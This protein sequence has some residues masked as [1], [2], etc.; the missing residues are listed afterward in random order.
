MAIK[1]CVRRATSR[2]FSRGIVLAFSFM[3]D[4]PVGA[5]KTSPQ[6]VTQMIHKHEFLG[7]MTKENIKNHIVSNY[8]R[9]FEYKDPVFTFESDFD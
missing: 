5:F 1:I 4:F 9:L 3:Y 8:Y 2:E 7:P 6:R